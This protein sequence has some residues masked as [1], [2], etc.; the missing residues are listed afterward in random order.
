MHGHPSTS[1][2]IRLTWP[3]GTR[4]PGPASIR[5]HGAFKRL[6]EQEQRSV[7]FN[8]VGPPTRQSAPRLPQ[9]LACCGAA[10]RTAGG[11]TAAPR[12]AA[13]ALR[14]LWLV[15]HR[16]VTMP[17][18]F[19]ITD[20][21]AT[22]S[23]I[24]ISATSCGQGAGASAQ[25]LRDAA[26]LPCAPALA[27]PGKAALR[28]GAAA[29]RTVHTAGVAR[30][31]ARRGDPRCGSCGARAGRSGRSHSRHSGPARSCTRR[32]PAINARGRHLLLLAASRRVLPLPGQTWTCQSCQTA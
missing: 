3:H 32:G 23:A 9:R 30:G 20:R 13:A 16:D 12:P 1:P 5:C 11:G 27:A 7:R 18:D 14:S 17:P 21:T 31:A 19:S 29:A 15:A 25:R 26:T 24:V 2:G 22:D 10:R 28:T 4:C 8:G 6:K